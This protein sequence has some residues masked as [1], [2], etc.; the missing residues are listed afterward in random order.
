M[1]DCGILTIV[2]RDN[3]GFDL[4]DGAGI[5]GSLE[6]QFCFGDFFLVL[7][8]VSLLRL[9]R[10]FYCHQQS[11]QCWVCRFLWCAQRAGCVLLL[12]LAI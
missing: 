6:V 3:V 5:A 4:L 9:V 7:A 10:C 12:K 11:G 2:W 1:S 8:V